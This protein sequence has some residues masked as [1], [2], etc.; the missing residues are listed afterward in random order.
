MEQY[1]G[2]VEDPRSEEAKAIDYKHSDVYGSNVEWKK[3]ELSELKHYTPRYQ[4][5]SLSCCGQGSA[6]GVETLIGKVMSAHPVYRS[7]ANYPQAGMWTQDIGECWKKVGSCLESEDKSQGQN[8]QELNRDITVPTPYKIKGY[9]QPNSKKI[10]EIAMAI[11]TWGHCMLIFHANHSEWTAKP[12]YNGTPVDFGHCICATDYFLDENGIKCLYIE[13]SSSPSTSMS[14]KKNGE[15]FITEDYLI[16]RC[17]SAI[18]FLGVNPIDLP[19]IF[20]KTLK[21]GSTGLDVKHLQK[22][23]GIKEDGVF[24]KQTYDAVR[25]FQLMH[26]LTNDGIVGKLT[27]SVLNS[28]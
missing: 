23:L 26:N 6:K 9:L 13:D 3:K 17:S 2:I 16:K 18:Y 22:K 19:Y 8:E 25:H 5:S 27:N 24:G 14:P 11:E 28:I 1:F 10:D 15:R 7:R 12:V 4:S 21:M 20:S